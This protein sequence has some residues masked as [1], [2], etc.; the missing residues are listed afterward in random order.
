MRPGYFGSH[1]SCSRVRA[2]EA[3]ASTPRKAA[4]KPKCSPAF[5]GEM[6]SWVLHTPRTQAQSGAAGWNHIGDTARDESLR[7]AQNGLGPPLRI[8]TVRSFC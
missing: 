8:V 2:L 5:S 4:R 6:D 1:P 7:C 3:G